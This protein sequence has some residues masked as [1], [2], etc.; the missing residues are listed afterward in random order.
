MEKPKKNNLKDKDSD[1]SNV[2]NKGS[3]MTKAWEALGK[4]GDHVLEKVIESES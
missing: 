3:I 2:G 4:Q 1:V